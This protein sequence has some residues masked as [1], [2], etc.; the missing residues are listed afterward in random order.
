MTQQT[1]ARGFTL[2]ET[3]VATG[4]LVTAI[5]GLAQLFAL[6]M[7]F[8]RD[9]DPFKATV[10]FDNRDCDI[11]FRVDNVEGSPWSQWWTTEAKLNEIIVAK[12][13]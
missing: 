7:R 3:L 6:S 12:I 4:V 2:V 10:A 9:S 5:A 11:R 1:S 8:T 13:A